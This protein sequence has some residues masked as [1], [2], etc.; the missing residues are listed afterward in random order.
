MEQIPM[1]II[2]HSHLSRCTN[3]IVPAPNDDLDDLLDLV[4]DDPLVDTDPSTGRP[5][6]S[7]TPCQDLHSHSD[8]REEVRHPGDGRTTSVSI[9]PLPADPRAELAAL[10]REYRAAERYTANIQKRYCDLSLALN[11]TGLWAPAYRPTLTIPHLQRDRKH[12]HKDLLRDRIIFDLHWM[13]RRRFNPPTGDTRIADLLNPEHPF[14]FALAREIAARSW[15]RDY[16][17]EVMSL[18]PQQDA[19]LGMLRSSRMRE[20]TRDCMEGNRPTAGKRT[21]PKIAAV[22]AALVRWAAREPRIKTHF[23]SYLDLWL[24]RELLGESATRRSI[25]ELA[26][27]MSGSAP[28][29]ERTASDQLAKLDRKLGR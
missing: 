6:T 22:R 23:Q 1:S 12:W 11:E 26:G 24:A 4:D 5:T 27:L 15:R 17:T 10:V 14:D 28:K 9:Q 18:T 2:D 29:H 3:R 8:T 7:A 21:P 20:L 13:H 16:R 19:E 25:S